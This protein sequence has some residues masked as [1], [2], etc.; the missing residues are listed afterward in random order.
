[1]SWTSQTAALETSMSS[2]PMTFPPTYSIPVWGSGGVSTPLT[3]STHVDEPAGRPVFFG[4]VSG[5]RI[6]C[7]RSSA[8]FLQGVRIPLAPHQSATQARYQYRA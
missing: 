5:C 3:A 4:V 6:P 8:P 1:L 2:V 7:L